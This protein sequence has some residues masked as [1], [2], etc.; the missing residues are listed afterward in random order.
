M[1]QSR[2]TLPT[3]NLAMNVDAPPVEESTIPSAAASAHTNF[4]DID[5]NTDDTIGRPIETSDSK[6]GIA[7]AKT[8]RGRRWWGKMFYITSPV[9][10]R[11]LIMNCWQYSRTS[12]IFFIITVSAILA[13][14]AYRFWDDLGLDKVFGGNGS[15]SSSD[16]TWNGEALEWESDGQGLEITIVNSLTDDWDP[17][18][19][20]TLDDW[21]ASPA[22]LLT[23]MERK[24]REDSCSHRDGVIR[25]CN[26]EY[27]KGG[28]KGLN[29]ATYYTA[30]GTDKKYLIS[31][32]AILNDSY[33]SGKSHAERLNAICHEV[34]HGYGLLHRD[35][36]FLNAD[37]GTCM[38]YTNNFES[39]SKPDD[40]DF[41]NL[42]TVYGVFA[43]RRN[44][45][46]QQ[47]IPVHT[48]I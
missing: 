6:A 21:A 24:G 44:L 5:I 42:A 15:S 20:E 29:E 4:E 18:F 16:I 43:A 27:G 37:L 17:Y 38:D 28:W 32:V 31:S 13:Y 14:I 30:E 2:D 34:G 10:S 33:L 23:T 41:Q 9:F 3:P 48:P 19:T 25:V 35:E 39:S 46:K 26:G 1:Q 8:D 47:E 7:T 11:L 45:R 12:G 36:N 40:I 22:L